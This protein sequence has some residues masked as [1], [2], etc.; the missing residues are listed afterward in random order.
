MLANN[1]QFQRHRIN[2]SLNHIRDHLTGQLNL[3]QLADAACL[4][5]YHFIR[6]FAQHLGE[7]PNQFIARRRLECATTKLVFKPHSS[8]T[9]IA[10]DSGFSGSD[11]F[12]RAFKAK[13]GRTPRSVKN[14]DPSIFEELGRNCIDQYKI[15]KPG[16]TI[17]LN[18]G[19]AFQ[20]RVEKKPAHYVCYMR[21][22]GSYG[23]ADDSIS[24][25]FAKLQD[26]ARSK[27]LLTHK[28]SF[29]GISHN[30][31]N[32]TPAGR[33]IYDVGMIMDDEIAEDESVSVQLVPQGY[34]AVMD[35]QCPPL[36][37]NRMWDW[38]LG[39]WFTTSKLTRRNGIYYEHFPEFGKRAVTALYGAQLCVPIE[40]P[41]SAF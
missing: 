40:A 1:R 17:T 7:T 29:I 33:C 35:V 16:H 30:D 37:L 6:V 24:N 2:R 27:G 8:I 18:D 9:N 31:C 39:N 15:Y 12:A 11:A 41:A 20:V 21:H 28:S 26:W 36:M 19:A 13:Y 10:L 14:S 22:I 32:S 3:D 4:S 25:T 5:K 38:F 23:D 34:Y